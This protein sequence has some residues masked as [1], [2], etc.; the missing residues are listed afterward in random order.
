[1]QLYQLNVKWWW[2]EFRIKTFPY[3]NAAPSIWN[4]L[5]IIRVARNHCLRTRVSQGWHDFRRHLSLCPQALTPPWILKKGASGQTNEKKSLP[6]TMSSL[7][8]IRKRHALLQATALHCLRESSRSCQGTRRVFGPFL[9]VKEWSFFVFISLLELYFSSSALKLKKKKSALLMDEGKKKPFCLLS[10]TV[11]LLCL[12]SWWNR[13]VPG[14]HCRIVDGHRP[15]NWGSEEIRPRWHQAGPSPLGSP[16]FLGPDCPCLS[17][18]SP[19]QSP[20]NTLLHLSLCF[21]HRQIKGK[22]ITFHFSIAC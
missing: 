12:L 19:L 16:P 10:N 5:I 15:A 22:G 1:M 14:T 18:S 8:R 6:H 13:E 7:V 2:K 3:L 20:L 9:S 17:L 21:Y 11:Y 4:I